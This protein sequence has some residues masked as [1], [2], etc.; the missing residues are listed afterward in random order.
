MTRAKTQRQEPGWQRRWQCPFVSNHS[1]SIGFLTARRVGILAWACCENDSRMAKEHSNFMLQGRP[2]I[3]GI[4]PLPQTLHLVCLFVCMFW[5]CFIKRFPCRMRIAAH[6]AWELEWCVC[7]WFLSSQRVE[8]TS[9]WSL[10]LQWS[11][12]DRLLT[13]FFLTSTHWI[14]DF[15]SQGLNHAPC[16]GRLES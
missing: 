1:S 8:T 11:L 10:Y 3:M 15:P 9:H 13:I 12:H 4:F 5:Y 2:K 16:I 7:L 6:F 14:H